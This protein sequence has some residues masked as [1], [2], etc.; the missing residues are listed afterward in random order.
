LSIIFTELG[1][2]TSVRPSQALKASSSIF[3]KEL[4]KLTVVILSP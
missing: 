3:F 2:L 1:K 4:G